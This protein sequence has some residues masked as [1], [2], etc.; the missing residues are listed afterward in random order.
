MR[1]QRFLTK[2]MAGHIVFAAVETDSE[3]AAR[4]ALIKDDSVWQGAEFLGGCD[5]IDAKSRLWPVGGLYALIWSETE[6]KPTP[7]PE[8][9]QRPTPAKRPDTS[10]WAEWHRKHKYDSHDPD[11]SGYDTPFSEGDCI[12]APL[13]ER[14]DDGFRLCQHLEAEFEAVDAIDPA[15]VGVPGFVFPNKRLARRRRT[16]S[17]SP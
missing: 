12:P 14:C 9:V 11:T 15:V 13:W 1:F 4:A 8:P 7:A 5:E 6:P 17:P 3:H 2:K 16:C 10:G